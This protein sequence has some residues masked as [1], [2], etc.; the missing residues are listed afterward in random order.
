MSGN[1]RLPR[2]VRRRTNKDGSIVFQARWRDRSGKARAATFDTSR[3]AR[4][5]L[6]EVRRR[7]RSG[8][9][10]DPTLGHMLFQDWWQV[11]VD[12]SDSR[13]STLA[14][15]LSHA[16]CHVLPTWGQVRLCDVTFEDGVRWARTIQES[17]LASSTQSK[18]INIFKSA[19]AAAVDH[20]RLHVDPVAHLKAPDVPRVEAVFLTDAELLKLEA[21]MDGWWALTVPFVADTGLRISELSALRVRDVDLA[22]GIVHIRVGAVY[23]S[24]KVTG[25]GSSRISD[26]TKTGAAVRSIPTLTPAMCQRV[27]EHIEQRGLG[28]DD[29]LFTGRRGAPLHPTNYRN[30]VLKPAVGRAGLYAK[31]VTPHSLRHSAVARW[32]AA[33]VR[34]PYKLSRWAGH[35]GI[36][37]IYRLY[38]HLLVEPEEEVQRR[39]QAQ[40]TLAEGRQSDNSVQFQKMPIPD[41]DEG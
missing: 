25:K 12:A 21:A 23:V 13:P 27:A 8:H 6:D 39:L 24:K 7:M 16:R 2:G 1:S 30:R 22:A 10:G 38:G 19:M 32:I 35:E 20:G 4:D 34:E 28:P 33:D 11:C 31:T 18:V 5:H 3:E 40:R 9:S 37:T 17:G 36:S 15:D 26:N 14:R 29:L 41:G